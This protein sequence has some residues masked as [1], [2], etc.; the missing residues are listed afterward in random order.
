M[1]SHL[2]RLVQSS[3]QSHCSSPASLS[4]PPQHTRATETPWQARLAPPFMLL[5]KKRFVI[6]QISR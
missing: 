1:A 6:Q 5:Q 2:N 3:L 4:L